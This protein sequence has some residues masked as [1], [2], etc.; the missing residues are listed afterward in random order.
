[1]TLCPHGIIY[2]RRTLT[3]DSSLQFT[4]HPYISKNFG[5]IFKS[6]LSNTIKKV[7]FKFQLI[8][9][10]KKILQARRRNTIIV[11][12]PL[13]EQSTNLSGSLDALAEGQ[14]DTDE[15]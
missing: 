15:G 10:K 5:Y 9:F 2:K 3:L 12:S 7:H 13:H 8:N 1:M 4:V 14:D 6:G 11:C